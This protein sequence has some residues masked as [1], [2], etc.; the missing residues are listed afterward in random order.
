MKTKEKTRRT[1]GKLFYY[2]TDFF[3]VFGQSSLSDLLK[4]KLGNIKQCFIKFIWD[5]MSRY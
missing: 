5:K 2:L 1:N 4:K 3:K